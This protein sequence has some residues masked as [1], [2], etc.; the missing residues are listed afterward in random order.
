[1]L[2]D[3]SVTGIAFIVAEPLPLFHSCFICLRKLPEG[4]YSFSVYI[5][6]AQ[7]FRE[8]L[9]DG[10]NILIKCRPRR[11][12]KDEFKGRKVFDIAL[13]FGKHDTFTDDFLNLIKDMQ[14]D[15]NQKWLLNMGEIDV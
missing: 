9:K 5:R 8:M 2:R 1:M 11:F 6:G 3:I 15:M 7:Q 13:E 12:G 10:A 14:N 4:L